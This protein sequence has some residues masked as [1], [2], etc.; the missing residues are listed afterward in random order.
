MRTKLDKRLAAV[1][2]PAALLAVA[3]AALAQEGAPF[4]PIP[5]DR[6]VDHTVNNGTKSVVIT[7]TAEGL[8]GHGHPFPQS[9]PFGVDAT[10]PSNMLPTIYGPALDS[11][12]NPIPNTLPSTPE[13]PYN[14]HPDPVVT[15]LANDHGPEED[16][17]LVIKK[18]KEAISPRL[19]N[20]TDRTLF[21]GGIGVPADPRRGDRDVAR[22][23]PGAG[24]IGEDVESRIRP[25]TIQFGIDILEGNAVDRSYSGMPLLNYKGPDQLKVVDAAT[26]TVTVH[27]VWTRA[28]IMSDTFF[29]DPSNVLDDEWTIHYVIDV[30]SGGHED[31]AP[32]VMYFDDPNLRGGAAVPAT[33]F[34][35][36][37]FP[38]EEGLRYEFDYKM[39]PGRFW[40]LTYHWGWRVHPPRIQAIENARKVA[41]GKTLVEWEQEVFGTNPS[42][43][44]A[45]KL[46]AISMIGDLAPA[47]RMWNALRS[48]KSISEGG[49]D[50]HGGRHRSEVRLH[51]EELEA[52]F[53]DWKN[54]NLLPSGIEADPDADL[55][56]VYLNNTLYG[57]VKD[58]DGDAQVQTDA[59]LTR[60]DVLNVK[61]LNGD[62]FLH[63]Y[64]NI[65]FGGLRGWENTFQNTM[66]L[67]GQ[68]PW[69]TFGRTWWMPNLVTPAMVPPATKPE[70]AVGPSAKRLQSFGKLAYNLEESK[71]RK[72]GRFLH[73]SS[74]FMGTGFNTS[75]T[76]TEGLGERDI[77][78]HYRFDPALRLKFYQF[79]PFHHG[80]A[81][82]SVH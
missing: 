52:A 81:I 50:R 29:I 48:L 24:Q 18:L 57:Q 28:A 36:T 12:G 53:H 2:A 14:L 21:E 80:V 55:T 6:S 70:G 68:G 8:S 7:G 22:N 67:N 37:F 33:A 20:A 76:T 72:P 47:K 69:F 19:R 11:A 78:V 38:M 64:T 25:E 26:K 10:N 16:L 66:P 15:P 30:V 32:F 74:L 43:S 77:E 44:E 65:D 45:A 49:H 13:N 42:G 31:F 56:M 63:A 58:H 61:L 1:L 4:Q 62:Y 35:G 75:N 27:Q 39:A 9:F 3:G 79:D 5:M 73:D 71:A 59:F 23:D 34:D 54:R 51:V 60:G 17:A 46:A 40:N 41:A 82:W